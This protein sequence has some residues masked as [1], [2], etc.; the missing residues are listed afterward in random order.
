MPDADYRS[1]DDP[2]GYMTSDYPSPYLAESQLDMQRRF[3]IGKHALPGWQR[4][5]LLALRLLMIAPFLVLLMLF[6]TGR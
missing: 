1:D 3:L 6:V 2:L 4:C 5:L